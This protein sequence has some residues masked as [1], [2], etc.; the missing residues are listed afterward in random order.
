MRRICL[1]TQVV[2][3]NISVPL[4]SEENDWL[5]AVSRGRAGQCSGYLGTNYL[6][7][8]AHDDAVEGRWD[9]WDSGHPITF[10]GPWRG[11]GPNGGTVENCLV[12]LHG[13]FP[14]LWSD[15]ACLDTYSLCV[16]CEFKE[17]TTMYLKG[18][19][20]CKTSPFNAEYLLHM[21]F[22][23]RPSL[24]GF[25]HS[26]IYW[27]NDTV[28]WVLASRK[29]NFDIKFC[30]IICCINFF[31]AFI[32]FQSILCEKNCCLAVKFVL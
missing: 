6:W 29:V 27:S 12:M 14:G 7:L 10:Q 26:D 2:G 4:N 19:L 23:E 15:I 31:K 24:T 3:G 20:L 1:T 11:G 32:S 30:L 5:Y 25:L 18:E 9:H 22:I 17:Y 8:G 13:D 16:A 28:S 21:D